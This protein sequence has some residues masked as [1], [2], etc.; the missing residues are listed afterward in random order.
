[1]GSNMQRQAVP[2]L[3]TEAPFI[4]TGL[5]RKVAVDSGAVVT[6]K[7]DGKVSYVAGKKIVIETEDK[8]EY[9]YRLLNFERSNQSMCLHQSPLVNLGDKDRKSTRLNSS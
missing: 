1:M 5:E 9:T 2:L 4:G 6:T 8:R 7:V 3:R